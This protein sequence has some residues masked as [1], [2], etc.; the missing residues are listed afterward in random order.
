[1][2]APFFTIL[3]DTYNYREYI[4]EA[5][6]SA[7]AQNFPAEQREVLVV[8][9]GST[10]D[11]KWNRRLPRR[12]ALSGRMDFANI[13]AGSF[14]GSTFSERPLGFLGDH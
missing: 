1:M 7:L 9:D 3:I 5:V 10:C 4:E 8:D 12:E 11:G 14:C 6:A 2:K 13:R